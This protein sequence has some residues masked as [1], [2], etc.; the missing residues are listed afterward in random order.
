[1]GLCTA[2]R[3]PI[4]SPMNNDKVTDWTDYTS[5]GDYAV[6]EHKTDPLRAQVMHMRTGATRQFRGETSLHD[7][8]RWASDKALEELYR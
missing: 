8:M 6:M 5:E 4:L 7:A 2:S 1:M 3:R